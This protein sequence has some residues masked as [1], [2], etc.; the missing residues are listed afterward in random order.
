MNQRAHL[1]TPYLIRVRGPSGFQLTTRG[2][3]TRLSMPSKADTSW[4]PS[5]S[6]KAKIYFSIQATY[7]T[8]G[9]SFPQKLDSP[10]ARARFL[11]TELFTSA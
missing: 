8:N 4:T 11:T 10:V 6:V 3:V 7:F 2:G 1:P 9:F 5:T